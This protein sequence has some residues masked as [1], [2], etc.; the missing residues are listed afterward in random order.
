MDDEDDENNRG[1]WV[2]LVVLGVVAWLLRGGGG[3]S[4]GGETHV[5]VVGAECTV[6]GAAVDCAVVPERV[7]SPVI[8]HAS[9]G[10]QGVVEDLLAGLETAGITFTVVG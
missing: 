8:V 4:G 1:L 5:R 2:A 9:R 6:N 7:R 10:S 3:S